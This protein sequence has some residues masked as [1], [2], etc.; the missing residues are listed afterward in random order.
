MKYLLLIGLLALTSCGPSFTV[1]CYYKGELIH[2]E[3][4]NFKI[5]TGGDEAD[6][7]VLEE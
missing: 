2:V 6:K 7:C 3:R 1:K 5:F 4:T